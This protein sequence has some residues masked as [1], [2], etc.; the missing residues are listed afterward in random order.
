MW[1]RDNA[2]VRVPVFALIVCTDSK[3]R[4]GTAEGR[5]GSAMW[6]NGDVYTGIQEKCTLQ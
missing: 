1:G 2:C 3:Y 5:A 4:K 6:R